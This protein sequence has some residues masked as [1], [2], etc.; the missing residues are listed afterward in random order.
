M[1]TT[2]TMNNSPVRQIIA[3]VELYE[4]STLL[5]TYTYKDA[6][7]S[8]N[9]TKVGEDSKFFG[10]GVCQKANIHLRD[11]NREIG[12]STAN[13]I[14][15]YFGSNKVYTPTNPIYY[16][17]EVNRDENTNELSITAY[18][19][20]YKSTNHTVAELSLSSYTIGEFANACAT[21]LGLRSA[22]YSATLTEFNTEY[23]EG[24]NFE[25]TETIREAL[26]D[27][28]E[29]TQ[30]IYYISRDNVLY[31]KRLDKDGEA[32][33]TITKEDYFDS[34]SSTNRRL[35]TIT[36]ATVLG[37]DITSTTG[38][39]GSTQY[40]RNNPFWDL[41]EDIGDLVDNALAAIGGIVINQFECE[42]RGNY[43]LE[44]GDK[45]ALTTKDNDIVTSYVLNDTIDY[46][47][48]FTE[49]TSWYYEDDTAETSN[50]PTSLGEALKE[51]YAR[52]DKQNKE[53]QLVASEADAN[54]GAI[55]S[56]QLDTQS[57]S[58]SVQTI[59]KNTSETIDSINNSLGTLTQ[60]VSAK[61][62]ADEVNLSISTALENGVN[63]VE[64][65]TGFTFDDD[66]LTISRSDG[67]ISTRVTE[68]GMIVYENSN[69]EDTLL[70][71]NSAGVVAKDLH[72]KTYLIIGKYSRFEDY[73][74]TRT[75]CFWIGE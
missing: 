29:A 25:G 37:D 63:K 20:L 38:V 73:E 12:V 61:I 68:D 71:A 44:I 32:V 72:A 66:G 4:G 34:D 56:L 8:V 48:S 17:T 19:M 7:Q 16:I 13:S 53:I 2:A 57:I 54:Q 46:D 52:V 51:T 47:G 40:V 43:L 31:F 21:L 33:L 24:A 6:L 9:I 18:D 69:E 49:N 15:I 59:E 1:I 36:H 45:I 11:I 5:T 14:K 41:R 27:I 55:A 50:N 30:T 60:E 28:A 26:D 58:A 35:S 39:S 74:P 64:T 3:K 70:T 67:E 23:A 75:G 22:T 10:F 42:W 65:S 62:T